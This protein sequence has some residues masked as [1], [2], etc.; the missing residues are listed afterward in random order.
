[1]SGT[2]AWPHWHIKS[3]TLKCMAGR[4]GEIKLMF[5]IV[6]HWTLLCSQ[7]STLY[8]AMCIVGPQLNGS[9]W[10]SQSL[11][12]PHTANS[13]M[14]TLKSQKGLFCLVFAGELNK[15]LTPINMCSSSFFLLCEFLLYSNVTQLWVYRLISIIDYFYYRLISPLTHPTP[16]GRH[17]GLGWVP[18][19]V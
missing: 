5:T 8:S 2:T 18:C 10:H 15:N 19:A 3:T 14:T 16:L 12:C 9:R 11:T 6:H 13:T 4:G 7:H 17:R 1:M